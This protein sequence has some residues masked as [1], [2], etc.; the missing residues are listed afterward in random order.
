MWYV[1][2]VE[3]YAAEKKK[4]LLP[5]IISGI[6]SVSHTAILHVIPASTQQ[7]I[8]RWLG[9]VLYGSK[10]ISQQN[11]CTSLYVTL[12]LIPLGRV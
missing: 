11:A 10:L 7:E 3:Y 12:E 8:C 5:F 9:L 2:T 1:Y 4:K 6:W